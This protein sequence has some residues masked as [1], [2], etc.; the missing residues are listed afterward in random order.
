M[1]WLWKWHILEK[2]NGV[3]LYTDHNLSF[4]GTLAEVYRFHVTQSCDPVA[5]AK[6]NWTR[7]T[8]RPKDHIICSPAT[9]PHRSPI[10]CMVPWI[11]NTMKAPDPTTPPSWNPAVLCPQVLKLSLKVSYSTPLP[12]EATML[13]ACLCV[14]LSLALTASLLKLGRRTCL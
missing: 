13:L 12:L 3:L 2:S 5:L 14:M 8:T 7:I 10:Y 1:L 11:C 6:A 4:R 9:L